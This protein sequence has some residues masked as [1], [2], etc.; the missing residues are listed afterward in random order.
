MFVLCVHE[1]D[2]SDFYRKIKT[3]KVWSESFCKSLRTLK[4]VG[5]VWVVPHCSVS[6]LP[7]EIFSDD[8]VFKIVKILPDLFAC[9]VGSKMSSIYSW[10]SMLL[11]AQMGRNDLTSDVSHITDLHACG[12]LLGKHLS[13]NNV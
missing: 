2:H 8:S 6:L 1:A 13:P 12:I 9:M 11:F 10:D 3:T 5:G 7:R 4:C